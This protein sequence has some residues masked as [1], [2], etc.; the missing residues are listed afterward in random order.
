MSEK[1]IKKYFGDSNLILISDN[2][3]SGITTSI[4]GD[5]FTLLKLYGIIGLRLATCHFLN[6]EI[7]KNFIDK[8]L[9]DEEV[10]K[11]IND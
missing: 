1:E 3:K 7:V 10:E 4:K 2:G 8:M 11:I 9:T 5:S 6:K